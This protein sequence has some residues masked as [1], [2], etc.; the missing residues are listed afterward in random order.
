MRQDVQLEPEAHADTAGCGRGR[1]RGR[2]TFFF[3]YII[4]TPQKKAIAARE[5]KK[6]IARHGQQRLASGR[7]LAESRRELYAQ[8][9]F[10]REDLPSPDLPG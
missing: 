5:L 4:I 9:I 1:E 7:P 2:P 3:L 8:S 10:A 6:R